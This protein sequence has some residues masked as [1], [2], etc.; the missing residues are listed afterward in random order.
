MLMRVLPFDNSRQNQPGKDRFT[1][2]YSLNLHLCD[3][4]LTRR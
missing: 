4:E 1:Q 3:K 2:L